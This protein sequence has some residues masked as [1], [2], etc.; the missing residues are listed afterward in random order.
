[1]RRE[2]GHEWKHV[3]YSLGLEHTL[4]KTIE[5]NVHNIEE[6]AFN[7]LS[8]WIQRDIESCYCK[9]ITAMKKENLNSGI[10]HLKYWIRA[11]SYSYCF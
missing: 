5:S 11:G 10:E 3:G 8:Y 9:L 6:Q 2:F 7:M 1:M 4:L